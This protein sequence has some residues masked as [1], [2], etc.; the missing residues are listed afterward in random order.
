MLEVHHPA[1][2]GIDSHVP[3]HEEGRPERQDDLAEI[4]PRLK[5]PEASFDRRDESGHLE[6][7]VVGRVLHRVLAQVVLA[8]VE[9]RLRPARLDRVADRLRAVGH[10]PERRR[11]VVEL[12]EELPPRVSGLVAGEGR[13][14]V[15]SP[16]LNTIAARCHQDRSAPARRVEPEV[17]RA[18]RL[19]AQ[20]DRVED[21]DPRPLR[22]GHLPDDRRPEVVEVVGGQGVLTT[23]PS[24]SPV[25]GLVSPAVVA[26]DLARLSDRLA[27]ADQ[28]QAAGDLG[29][30]EGVVMGDRRPLAATNVMLAR[31]ARDPVGMRVGWAASRSGEGVALRAGLL[32]GDTPV[33]GSGIQAI[34]ADALPVKVDRADVPTRTR[35]S[36]DVDSGPAHLF[37]SSP[38]PQRCTGR[39]LHPTTVCFPP[40]VPHKFGVLPRL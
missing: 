4:L 5:A 2:L 15:S 10:D 31:G 30:A 28:N 11:I 24:H 22:W 39:Q 26:N 34:V 16:P 38:Q 33:S 36:F 35:R 32:I 18:V 12:A 8:R 23:R 9:V 29:D 3:L 6:R 14:P 27:L 25:I 40:L 13:Q 19:H 37:L 1:G 20:R 7:A 21:E 17:F